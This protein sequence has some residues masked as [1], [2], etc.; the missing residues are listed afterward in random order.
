[1]PELQDRRTVLVATL[2]YILQGQAESAAKQRTSIEIMVQ[3][4]ALAIAFH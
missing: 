4:R 2:I 1:V 3:A